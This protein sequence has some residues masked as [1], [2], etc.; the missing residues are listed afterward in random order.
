M[1]PA[2]LSART[3]TP[4]VGVAATP[5]LITFR[6]IAV[7]PP[8]RQAANIGPVVRPSRVITIG[9]GGKSA[10]NAQA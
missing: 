4:V 5:P 3:S 2:A 6:P 9:P 7:S 10:A 8:V 1:P